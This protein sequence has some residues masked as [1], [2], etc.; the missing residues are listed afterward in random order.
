VAKASNDPEKS[1]NG[2][3][4]RTG[5]GKIQGKQDTN[6][7]GKKPGGDYTVGIR[8]RA[9]VGIADTRRALAPQEGG[10][11]KTNRHSR[12]NL[13]DMGRPTK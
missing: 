6:V 7:N 12:A 3:R 5:K 10:R 13:L 2:S 11:K 8:S 4:S 1:C 9:A